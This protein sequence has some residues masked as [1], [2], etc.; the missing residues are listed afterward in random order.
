MTANPSL[1]RSSSEILNARTWLVFS[2][3]TGFRHDHIPHTVLAIQKL[4]I[5]H[6]FNVDVYDPQLP[7]VTLA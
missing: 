1:S 5:E 3:T 2:R 7:T 4:G 6:N